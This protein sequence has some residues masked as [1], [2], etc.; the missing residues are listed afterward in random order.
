MGNVVKGMRLLEKR[1][2]SQECNCNQLW[3]GWH[4]GVVVY[5]RH[6]HAPFPPAARAALAAGI[7]AIRKRTPL[8]G[9]TLGSHIVRYVAYLPRAR[10]GRRPAA[11]TTGTP[12]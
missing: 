11:G 3:I 9:V 7:P 12:R 6:A 8:D 4:R 1:V 5:G 10:S 2:E